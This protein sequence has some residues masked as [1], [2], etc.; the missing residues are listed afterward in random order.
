MT[1]ANITWNAKQIA[2]MVQNGSLKFDNAVQRGFVWDKKRQTLLIDS[3][4]RGYPIPPMYTIKVGTNANGTGIYDCLDGKQ[5]CTTIAQFLNDGFALGEMEYITYENGDEM[6]ISGLLF[7]E[8]DEELQDIILSYSL[9]VYFFTDIE[10]DE[11]VEM[12]ARLN[13]GKSLTAYELS[14]VKAKDLAGIQEMANHQ[15]FDEISNK[16]YTCEDIVVKSYAML[17]EDE[18][19]LDT[20]AIRP[21]IE[22][23]VLDDEDVEHL[24][25][26]FNLIDEARDVILEDESDPSLN[27]AIAK[28]II[29]K[30]HLVSIVPIAY[31]AYYDKVDA[32]LFAKFLQEFYSGTPSI[33]EKY[34]TACQSGSGHTQAVKDRDCALERYYMTFK[35]ENG[36]K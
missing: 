29:K 6:D 20:K 12:M 8:L 23:M 25:T 1:K 13:N 30:L 16:G 11:I 19:C 34:N 33:D 15:I 2:K 32:D 4:L 10:D 31:E 36:I 35:K 5:R 18:P 24:N 21:M 27:R 28:K 17:N 22:E 9:T 7:S 26:C 14:R 3:M